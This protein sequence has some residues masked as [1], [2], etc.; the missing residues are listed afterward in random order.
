MGGGARNG[1]TMTSEE[2][3]DAVRELAKDLSREEPRDPE[4]TLGGFELGARALDKC[5]ASLV[6]TN[7][8]FVFNCPMDQQFFA[9]TGIDAEEFKA[10]VATG[11]EDEEVDEWVKEHAEG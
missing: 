11:A 3:L 6:G 8:E 1:W 5:R 7:G 2:N 10:F 9:E 4:E